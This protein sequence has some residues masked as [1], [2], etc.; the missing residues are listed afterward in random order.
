[1][2]S[3]VCISERVRSLLLSGGYTGWGEYPVTVLDR[4][5]NELPGY[6]G[7]A[8]TGRG[9]KRDRTRS[10]VVLKPAPTPGGRPFEVYRGL[11]FSE[12]DW[13]GS[14]LFL[15]RGFIVVSH[16]V[17]DTLSSAKVSNIKLTPLT[18]VEIDVSLDAYERS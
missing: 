16:R 1:M 2:I 14:D 11:Y 5:G 9:G 12:E 15:V 4:K 13:D 10:S 18:E 6:S 17:R 7:L 8:V 3:L